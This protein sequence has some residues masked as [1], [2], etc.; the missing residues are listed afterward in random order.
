M[1]GRGRVYRCA[2][3]GRDLD[4]DET[5]SLVQSPSG[6]VAGADFFDARMKGTE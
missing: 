6:S 5:H 2:E 1:P 3:F 4:D